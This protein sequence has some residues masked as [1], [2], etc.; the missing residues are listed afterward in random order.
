MGRG[1]SAF[2]VDHGMHL[3]AT[4]LDRET[5]FAAY[6]FVDVHPL[7]PPHDETGL[8]HSVATGAL[9]FCEGMCTR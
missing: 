3:A 7:L 4:R 9:R 1:E 5:L 8:S 6:I 2:Q